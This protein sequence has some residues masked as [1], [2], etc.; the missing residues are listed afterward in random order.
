MHRPL[1]AARAVAAS[2]V[3]AAKAEW[4]GDGIVFGRSA[5][6][7][8]PA[9]ALGRGMRLGILAAFDSANRAGGIQGRMLKVI[10]H[11]VEG[12]LVGRLAIAALEK[13]GADLTRDGLLTTIRTTGKFT[14][15][16]LVMTVGPDKNNRLDDVFLTVIQTDGSF[17]PV[18]KLTM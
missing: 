17:K 2:A 16:G 11:D 5:P 8:G 10:S 18:Q 9:S 15:G 14:I 1:I 4:A 3:L 13:T 7:E 12:Y 6:L